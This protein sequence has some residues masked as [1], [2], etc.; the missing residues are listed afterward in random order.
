MSDGDVRQAKKRDGRWHVIPQG[1]TGEEAPRMMEGRKRGGWT[2][3][4]LSLA[5]AA[6]TVTQ[7]RVSACTRLIFLFPFF[8]A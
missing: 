7:A 1:Q 8:S 5:Q 4:A 2:A 6:V 3:A